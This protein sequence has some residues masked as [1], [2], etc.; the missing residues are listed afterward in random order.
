MLFHLFQL[1]LELP[2]LFDEGGSQFGRL[3]EPALRFRQVSLEGSLGLCWRRS[4]QAIQ[5]GVER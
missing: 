5:L 1:V 2:L 3:L 4:I